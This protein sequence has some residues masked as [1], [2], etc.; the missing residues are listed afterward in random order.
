MVAFGFDPFEYALRGG[1]DYTLLCTA[2][3]DKAEEIAQNFKTA[4]NRSLFFIG[5]TTEHNRLEVI[6]PDGTS[7]P[8]CPRGW[9]HFRIEKG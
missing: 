1:E 2:A 8:I 4:F 3:P 5:E 9:D 6:Y 7:K